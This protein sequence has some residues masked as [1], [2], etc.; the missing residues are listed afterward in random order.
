M[1]KPWIIVAWDEYYPFRCLDNIK[2][3]FETK[4][5]AEERVANFKSYYDYVEVINI[6]DYLNDL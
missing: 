4:E 6:V 2:C 3:A 1:N 5:D